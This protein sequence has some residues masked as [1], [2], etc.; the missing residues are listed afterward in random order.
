MALP[1]PLTDA[2]RRIIELFPT[3]VAEPLRQD[4]LADL[5]NAEVVEEEIGDGRFFYRITFGLMGQER[6]PFQGVHDYQAIGTM[7]DRD[8]KLVLVDVFAA[9][10]GLYQMDCYR[11]GDAKPFGEL[12]P[13]TLTVRRNVA[14]PWP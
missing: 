3:A 9:A 6:P 4:L 1:R 7:Q 12:R 11:A 8:G 14:A 10:G 2:E 5:A 13:E